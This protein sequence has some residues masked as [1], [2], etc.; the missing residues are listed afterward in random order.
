MKGP[1]TSLQNPRIKDAIKLRRN[2][3]RKSQK[4][5]LIDG[6]REV[7]RALESGIDVL[8]LFVCGEVAV[9]GEAR[10]AL[11]IAR[12]RHTEL[13]YVTPAVFR[14][15]AFGMREEGLMAVAARPRPNWP[16]LAL[17][18]N[19]LVAVLEGVEKPGNLGGVLRTADAVGAAVLVAD[20]ATDL[21]SPHAVRASLGAIFHVPVA[22]A[23]SREILNWLRD[24]G[25]QVLAARVDGAIEY[26]DA[27]LS[28]PTAIVL[29]N[30]ATGLSD[31]WRA[32][33][34]P[35][36]SLPMLGRT[37]SLNVSVAAGVLL[38]E[39]HRQRRARTRAG[40]R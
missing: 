40:A 12:E 20:P 38:Y 17:P 11:E 39:A 27:D 31:T 4:K 18:E 10:Q 33:D 26:S 25:M 30:E 6:A 23:P 1:I 36:I 2:R 22:A 8:E 15:L 5:I 3:G 7:L 14:K 19:P 9:R 21:Y 13:L 32:K 35:A 29:G 16:T 37:D 24:R 28:G 34:I